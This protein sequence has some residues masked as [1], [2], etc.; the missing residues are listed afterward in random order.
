MA[1]DLAALNAGIAMRHSRAGL[2]RARRRLRG[3]VRCGAAPTDF[4]PF[5]PAALADPY[6]FYRRL[7]EGPAV[8]HHRGR[9][10][11]ILSGYDAVRAAA[12]AHDELSSAES[13]A[14][15]RARL[16]MMLTTDRPEH[17]RLRQLVARDFTR[18]RLDAQAPLIER[19][20]VAAIDELLAEGGGDWV[21]RLAEPLPVAVIAG[22]LG[23]P[24]T[25]LGRF[26]RWSDELVEGLAVTPGPGAA[27]ASLG[28]FRASIRLRSYFFE[29]ATASERPEGLLAALLAGMEEGRLS[30]DEVFWFCLMLLVAGNETT[31]N[32]LGTL[33]LTLGRQPELYDRLRAEPE[34]IPA[35]VEEGLRHTSPIQ[36]L[37]RS[38]RREYRVGAARIPAGGRVLL[39]FGAANR[40]PRHYPDP[41]RFDLDRNPTDHVAFGSGIH[42]CLG[43]HLARLEAAI[44]L[45][46]LRRRVERIEVANTPE[47][48]RNPSLRGLSHLPLRLS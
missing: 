13:V 36:G 30:E 33:V 38:A 39:L 27:R 35:A 15:Y 28:V 32:L 19:L 41:D 8:H 12:R 40:D 45:R 18:A 37:Y 11:W 34:L 22:M 5:A 26:R 20:A 4:D 6:P 21:K 14:R 47:W 9:A 43:A 10:L 24:S 44:V 48:R 1:L 3:D 17:S 46:E 25:D 29:Q 7:H 16:P 2:A 23:V 42:F 31:S